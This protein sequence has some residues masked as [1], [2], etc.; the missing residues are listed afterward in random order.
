MILLIYIASAALFGLLT[1]RAALSHDYVSAS[2][3][4]VCTCCAVVSGYVQ[5][6]LDVYGVK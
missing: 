3:S 1:V 2:F 6:R 4:F 5:L